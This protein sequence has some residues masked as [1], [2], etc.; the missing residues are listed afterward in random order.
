MTKLSP[1]FLALV[2][3]FG[4][5]ELAGAADA[6]K[7]EMMARRWCAACHVVAP[8]QTSGNTQ[9]PP[10]SA[11]A[12][13]PGFDA[14]QLALFLLVPHPQMPDMGF[15]RNEAADLAAYIASQK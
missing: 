1:A 4:M 11:I 13:K 10:F 5:S 8:D 12:G 7:G 14:A 9:A 15:S 3:T 2:A 6:A